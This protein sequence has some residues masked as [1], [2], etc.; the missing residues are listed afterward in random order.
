LV[1]ANGAFLPAEELDFPAAACLPISTMLPPAPVR[2]VSN[3]RMASPSWRCA[4]A[5]AATITAF[6]PG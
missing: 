1:A 4:S 5:L 2:D 3:W 6:V